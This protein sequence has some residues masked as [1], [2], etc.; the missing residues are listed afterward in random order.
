MRNYV[1][2][3]GS[4]NGLIEQFAVIASLQAQEPLLFE[5]SP[6]TDGP[7]V[8][9]PAHPVPA[10]RLYLSMPRVPRPSQVVLTMMSLSAFVSS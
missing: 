9:L 5:R 3:R 8:N 6:A 2:I 10:T 1:L 4:S 7:G